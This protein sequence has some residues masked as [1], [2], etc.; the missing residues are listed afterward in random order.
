MGKPRLVLALLAIAVAATVFAVFRGGPEHGTGAAAQPAQPNAAADRQETTPVG[1]VAGVDARRR[2]AAVEEEPGREE[3]LDAEVVRDAP[4]RASGLRLTGR[5]VDEHAN[6]IAGAE[7]FVEGRDGVFAVSDEAGEVVASGELGDV[8]AFARAFG[9]EVVVLARGFAGASLDVPWSAD[10]TAVTLGT[11]VL[12]PGRDLSGSVRTEAGLAV[13]GADLAWLPVD[14]LPEDA[15]AA[16]IEGVTVY[17]DDQRFVPRTRSGDEGRFE[18][19]GVPLGLGFLSG[20]GSG[21]D[22]GWTEPVDVTPNFVAEL[23]LVLPPAEA[24]FPIAGI[25]LLPDG[26]PAA[27][28]VSCEVPDSYRRTTSSTDD[29]GRFSFHVRGDAPRL[30]VAR[31]ADDLHYPARREGV[32]PGTVTLELRLGAPEWLAIATRDGSGEAVPWSHVRVYQSERGPT[33]E[34]GGANGVAR[35]L[36]PRTSFTVHVF[37]PGFRPETHGPFDPESVGERLELT[38]EPGS[39]VR[40]RVLYDGAPV[41]GASVTVNR[42]F[43]GD[44]IGVARGVAD[45]ETPFVVLTG[46]KK[47]DPDATTDRDGFFVATLHNDGPH[48]V[49]V[50]AEGFPTTT[51]GPFEW[52]TAEG[53]DDVEIELERGGALTGVVLAREG[54]DVSGEIVGVSN[55]RGI[56]YTCVVDEEGRY[57]FDDLQPGDWQVRRCRAPVAEVEI[58]SFRPIQRTAWKAHWDCAVT[59][60]RVTTFDLDLTSMGEFVLEGRVRIDGVDTA[61]WDVHLQR[62]GSGGGMLGP[63]LASDRLDGTG[64]FAFKLSEGGRRLIVVRGWGWTLLQEVDLTRGSTPWNVEL[65]TGVLAVSGRR[66]VRWDGRELNAVRALVE[67][68]DGLVALRL[69]DVEKLPD[70]T[71]ITTGVPAGSARLVTRAGTRLPFDGPLAE[72]MWADLA[73]VE[74]LPGEEIPVRLP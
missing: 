2:T 58:L 47:G 71:V 24:T 34:P 45:P 59:S 69:V 44:R 40:G 39:A 20:S 53:A 30:I 5:I 22:H 41:A 9:L 12:S 42:S 10:E 26:S 13:A 68:E 49:R 36:R 8:S 62:E 21:T 14:H 46:A 56:A 67:T 50:E 28:K 18:L 7:L 63:H 70:E 43:D 32:L 57:R 33:L 15:D 61:G 66:P 74:V 6:P 3:S 19:R 65:A 38:L 35:V 72:G 48:V 11:I 54:T 1:G 37:A 51:R 73:S 60:G 4:A 55:G 27:A 64:R 29:A 23:E 52:T 25:V 31:A 16:R 17:V